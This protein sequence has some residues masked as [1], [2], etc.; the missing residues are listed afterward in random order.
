MARVKSVFICQEC[1]CQSPRW[2]GR[3]PECGKWNTLVETIVKEARGKKLEARKTTTKPQRLSEIKKEQLQRI[4]TKIGEFD[5]VLGGGIVPGSVVL[6][7]GEPGIGKSTLLLQVAAKV[8]D[9]TQR[10]AGSKETTSVLYVSGEES[11]AQVKLR[12]DRLK[13]KSDNLLLLSETDVDSIAE[14]IEQLEAEGKKLEARNKKLE[15]NPASS[16][17][18]LA[19]VVIIDSIQSLST[20]DLSGAPGSVGQV[21]ECANR[22]HCLAKKEHFPLFLIGHVTKE[23]VIAGPKVL[24]HLV[25]TVLY[26]EGEHFQAFRLLRCLKNRFGPTDE[27]GVF[28]MKE[29]GLTEVANPSEVFLSQRQAPAPGSAVAATMEGN[30][31]ILAEIQALAVPSQL[32]VPRRTASG[33]SYQRLVLL[34]AVLQK[35]L[36]L[37]LGRSDVYVSVAGGLKV[38]EPAADLGVCLALISSLKN[39]PLKEKTAVF[40]E[41]G[42]LGEVRPVGFSQRRQ[43]EAKKLGF[44]NLVSAQNVR[45][46]K[47]AIKKAF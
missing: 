36:G 46:L 42:L 37:P 6:V 33:V 21:R 41:V 28:Q 1:G 18:P 8:A 23:G 3:C 40:G 25:D 35:T 24:E 45:N 30:R 17:Q 44:S 15:G 16:F 14:Q 5:R 12:A 38:L 47:E 26:L 29:E 13:V 20:S 22:L 2:V 19:S 43:K 27:I 10:T 31:P 39:K 7:A 9:N 4:S 32:V 11:A 34:C